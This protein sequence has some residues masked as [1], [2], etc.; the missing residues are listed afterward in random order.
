MFY[1]L[2]TASSE[3]RVQ[4]IMKMEQNVLND[5]YEFQHLNLL[6]LIYININ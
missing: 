1:N 6:R 5:F 2:N 4:E 3:A